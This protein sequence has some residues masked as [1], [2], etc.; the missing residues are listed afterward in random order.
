[1]PGSQQQQSTR[2]EPAGCCSAEVQDVELEIV[3]GVVM[4]QP[5]GISCFS[6]SDPI[7][8]MTGEFTDDLKAEV[9]SLCREFWEAS[10]REVLQGLVRAEVESQMQVLKSELDQKFADVAKVRES[11]S[12]VRTSNISAIELLLTDDSDVSDA[13]KDATEGQREI[14]EAAVSE[15]VS[16]EENKTEGGSENSNS[17]TETQIWKSTSIASSRSR[18]QIWSD[19][20]R[21]TIMG[22]VRN[23]EADTGK[24]FSG[25]DYLHSIYK[26]EEVLKICDFSQ[27][28]QD[29][30]RFWATAWK[31]RKAADSKTK[32]TVDGVDGKHI[33][34]NRFRTPS[35]G[36]E[37]TRMS[38]D[39]AGASKA[40]W[41]SDLSRLNR[42]DFLPSD[43]D[44]EIP[45]AMFPLYIMKK[46]Q[47]DVVLR[48]WPLACAWIVSYVVGA[49]LVVIFAL[50]S[51]SDVEHYIDYCKSVNATQ[52][53]TS[54]D[55]AL[56]WALGIEQTSILQASACSLAA[57]LCIVGCVYIA[58]VVVIFRPESTPFDFAEKGTLSNVCQVTKTPRGRIFSVG[59]FSA[60]LLQLMSMY[61]C[62]LYRPWTSNLEFPWVLHHPALQPQGP[63][64]LRT[65]WIVF[66]QV[67][68][69]FVAAIPSLSQDRAQRL[70]KGF[71]GMLTKIH[72][73]LAPTSIGFMGVMELIQLTYGE[74][75]FECFFDE[76]C[77]P[78]G[79]N[80]TR[81][82]PTTPFQRARAVLSLMAF[83]EIM[84]FL[85]LQVYMGG[86][87]HFRANWRPTSNRKAL[88]SFYC[89]VSALINIYALPA[90]AG[91]EI[92][93][94]YAHCSVIGAV[95]EV[96]ALTRMA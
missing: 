86:S 25:R 75:A 55:L 63:R 12:N 80:S 32:I 50:S 65:M 40:S 9:E 73:V 48:G 17:N 11:E 94:F 36:P 10:C 78:S 23:T 22:F 41:S 89:E 43:L 91:C 61:T 67:G 29:P 3:H 58:T 76:A 6:R 18:M 88:I 47:I 21:A 85:G 84:I 42:G 90:M 38:S 71:E 13:E 27:Y 70:T 30:S 59:L 87:K 34:M 20:A 33:R 74:H 8:P 52:E 28:T 14:G 83:L 44:W 66:P 54:G 77:F 79:W 53:F 19:K 31:L 92:M 16:T 69:M 68:L 56:A 95:P 60:C 57:F 26:N 51:G 96:L 2:E 62:W 93:T 46:T 1:M 5:A 72:N 7:P 39:R 37:T 64:N 24:S 35:D 4:E 45:Q 15:H 49:L 82:Y 81:P